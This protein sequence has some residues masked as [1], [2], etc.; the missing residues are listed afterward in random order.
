M[1]LK[2]QVDTVASLINANLNSRT[3][4][5]DGLAE[6]EWEDPMLLRMLDAGFTTADCAFLRGELK[7]LVETEV[8]EKISG[9]LTSNGRARKEFRLAVRGMEGVG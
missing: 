3:A 4:L 8:R 9:S 6:M 7:W 5:K 1:L 2:E